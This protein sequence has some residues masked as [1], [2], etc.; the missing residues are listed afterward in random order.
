MAP[1][2][3]NNGKNKDGAEGENEAGGE[4]VHR[5]SLEENF[6]PWQDIRREKVGG[7]D[8]TNSL[9]ALNL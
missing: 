8:H 5:I 7:E 2:F 3:L 9:G 4:A 6:S 1:P